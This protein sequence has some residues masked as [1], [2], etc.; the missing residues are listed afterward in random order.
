MEAR[1]NSR[2]SGVICRGCD[3][4]CCFAQFYRAPLMLKWLIVLFAAVLV[5]GLL[6]PRAG[7]LLPLGRLPGDLRFRLRGKEYS[8][9]FAS[10]VV[11]SL[12]AGLIGWLL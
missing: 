12:I 3:L 2:F 1:G 8:F 6:Q 11:F 4:I 10:A 9:P 7:R 5:V